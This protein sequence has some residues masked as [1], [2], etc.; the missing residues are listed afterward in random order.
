MQQLVNNFWQTKTKEKSETTL[1]CSHLGFVLIITAMRKQD[2]R[3]AIL[4]EVRHNESIVE[5]PR[6]VNNALV[7][8]PK[9]CT[10]SKHYTLQ[11]AALNTLFVSQFH[12][13]LLPFSLHLSPTV[14]LSHSVFI[15]I[16]VSV[17]I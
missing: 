2:F 3:Y 4:G 17:F 12:S 1:V 16:F 11:G 8:R 9:N 5:V 10:W 13:F 7:D 15:F 14:C 6:E